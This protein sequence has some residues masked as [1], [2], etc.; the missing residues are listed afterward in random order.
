M[1]I[2]LILFL[3]I[4]LSNQKVFSQC[5][6]MGSVCGNSNAGVLNKNSLRLS[7][8]YKYGYYET[9]Y[10]Q[11]VQ[12]I[13]YG[14]IKN[15]YYN[16][17]ILNVGFGV[18]RRLTI[19]DETCYFINKVQH[20]NDTVR[21]RLAKKGYGFS[22]GTVLAKY[23]LYIKPIKETE[24]TIGGG[25]KYPFTTEAQIV[26]NVR[27]PLEVQPSTRAFGFVGMALLKKGF[28]NLGLN[29]I[30]INRFETNLE[31]PDKYTSGN[32]NITSF[33]ISKK[34]IPNFVGI[35]TFRNDYKKT[36]RSRIPNDVL[37]THGSELFFISPSLTYYIAGTYVVSVFADIP[38]YKYYRSDV[39]FDIGTGGQISNKYS[40]G[41]SV[42]KD[43]DL[44]K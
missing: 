9:Y 31:N 26:N 1:K 43:F 39:N 22:H 34:I 5:C 21:E 18:T 32:L 24:I 44:E 41:I 27:L 42:T 16:F 11:D 3:V 8:A 23:G 38:L 36:D 12:L 25:V 40:V 37:L 29:F 14:P 33:I 35:L 4:G 20:F 2:F 15:M 19:E 28:S 6:G 17:S 13:N 30:L 7:A 10:H